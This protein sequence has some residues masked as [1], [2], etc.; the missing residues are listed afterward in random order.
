MKLQQ[1][2]HHFW[3]WYINALDREIRGIFF[4]GAGMGTA[5]ASIGRRR[6]AQQRTKKN[7]Q[8]KNEKEKATEKEK[9]KKKIN[10]RKKK[11]PPPSISFPPYVGKEISVVGVARTHAG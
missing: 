11:T 1:R 8:R 6:V 7:K 10:K 2:F 4:F 5:A 9:D 3:I